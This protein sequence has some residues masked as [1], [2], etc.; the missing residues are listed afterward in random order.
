M[1]IDKAAHGSRFMRQMDIADPLTFNHQ[2]SILGVG[3][4]GSVVA[5]GAAKLGTPLGINLVDFDLFEDHNIPNQICLEKTHKGKFKAQALAELCKDFGAM[6]PVKPLVA[7]LQDNGDLEF[8]DGTNV[9]TPARNQLN[10]IVVNTPDSMIARKALWENVVRLNPNTPWIIDARL[11][12]PYL[13]VICANSMQ[14]SDIKRYGE[15][16]YSDDKASPEP[17][18]ARAVI[19]YSLHAGSWVSTLIRKIQTKKPI[20]REIRLDIHTGELTITLHNGQTVS[21][22]EAMAIATAE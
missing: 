13:M 20:W 18:G 7:K 3:A 8:Q 10:G 11:A 15:T 5:M 9:K 14:M 22:R 17:C 16:L 12:G 19:D 6:G 1:A 4:I 2:V 21:N